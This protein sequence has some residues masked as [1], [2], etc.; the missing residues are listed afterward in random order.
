MY[1]IGSLPLGIH[2]LVKEA[3]ISASDRMRTALPCPS[4]GHQLA[5]FLPGKL[6]NISL[7]LAN[8]TVTKVVMGVRQLSFTAELPPEHKI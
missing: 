1:E 2:G 8:K 3:G 5:F 6:R 7:A 4:P